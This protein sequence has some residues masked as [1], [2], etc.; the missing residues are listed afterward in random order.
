MKDIFDIQ[1]AEIQI[2]EKIEN[3]FIVKLR[4][5]FQSQSKLYL[6]VD[7]MNGG[8]LFYHLKKH[9]KFT[10]RTTKFYAAQIALGLEHLHSNNII[11]RDLKSENV[12]LD[13]NGNV[14]LAD[15]GLSKTDVTDQMPGYS[16]CGTPE[17]LA[18][19]IIL[20]QGHNKAV[21]WWSYGALVYEM[22][23]GTP[24]FY[25]GNKKKMFNDIITKDIP[26]P[27]YISKDAQLFLRQ[28][29]VVNI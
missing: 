28:L 13:Q 20:K 26:M 1:M 10:E 15:F 6:V 16:I 29:L 3:Q 18:P 23:T 8:D 11:Y 27:N 19:E 17:Y 9:G 22:L 4:Y 7:F 21:D 24:P 25:S 2:L 12:L 14:K 5:A